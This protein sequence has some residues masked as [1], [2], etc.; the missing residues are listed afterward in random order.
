M[1]INY[2]DIINDVVSKINKKVTSSAV[3]EMMK[4]NN[5]AVIL[6]TTGGNRKALIERFRGSLVTDMAGTIG[7][8]DKQMEYMMILCNHPLLPYLHWTI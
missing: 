5:T 8:H 1:K 3:M 4:K 2:Y 7:C 6:P